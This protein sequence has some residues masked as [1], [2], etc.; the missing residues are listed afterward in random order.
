MNESPELP[1]TPVIDCVL[2]SK[3]TPSILFYFV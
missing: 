3:F 2:P 1:E